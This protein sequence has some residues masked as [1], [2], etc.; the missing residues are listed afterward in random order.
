MKRGFLMGGLLLG[1]VFSGVEAWAQTG[2]ARGKVT[3]DK[4]QGLPE[5]KILIEFQGGVTRKFETKTNKKGEFTQVGLQP[6]VYRFTASKDGFQ[7]AY[8]D[9][10]VSL[11][12]PTYL[13][14]IQLKPLSAAGAGGAGG[15][16]GL[17]ELKGMVDKAIELTKAGKY[18]EAEAAYKEAIAKSP[19][20]PQLH[21]NLAIVYAQKKDFPA[22]EAE[23]QKA[24]EVDPNYTEA[25]LGLA[26]LY[27]ASNQLPK[28]QEMAQKAVAAHP[29]DAKAQFLL[30]YVDFNTGK[31]DEATE[32]F[33]KAGSLDPSNAEVH[34]YLGSIAVG[35]GKTEEC[36]AELEKYLAASPTNQQ[37]VATAKGLI[38]ALKPKK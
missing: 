17:A 9:D 36:I 25:F 4:G 19:S 29:D 18:D 1:F 31:Q 32:A 24:M 37:N 35:Q 8:M 15:G 34:F 26:N 6:G 7:P 23:Y 22:A 38:A 30:G 21:H 13:A 5:V 12:D 33:K 2:T 28:A 14:D 16:G 11:G 3:D 10:K 27:L 20:I